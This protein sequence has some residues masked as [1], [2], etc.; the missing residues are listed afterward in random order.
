M[1]RGLKAGTVWINTWGYFNDG[2]E[3]GGFKQSGLGRSRGARAME[4]FQEVKARYESI[5]L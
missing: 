3:E 1:S 5:Q 4:E 2:F